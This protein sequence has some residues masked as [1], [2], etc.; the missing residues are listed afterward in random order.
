M[1]AE[2]ICGNCTMTH[3]PSPAQDDGSSTQGGYNQGHKAPS[4]SSSQYRVIIS[5]TE[6]LAAVLSYL[7]RSVLQKL[8]YKQQKLTGLWPLLTSLIAQGFY[9]RHGREYWEYW[10]L[11]LSCTQSGGFM[12]A[13]AS[14][15]GKRVLLPSIMLLI[16]QGCH[17]ETSSQMSLITGPEPWLRCYAHGEKQL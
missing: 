9:V 3:S 2:R 15:E 16:T 8:Y 10:V 17:S 11:L 4:L 13:K 5:P 6:R 1:I 14:Q 7:P 12:L